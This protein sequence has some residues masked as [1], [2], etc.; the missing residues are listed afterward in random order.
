MLQNRE[1]LLQALPALADSELAPAIGLIFKLASETSSS[2]S[3]AVRTVRQRVKKRDALPGAL[4]AIRFAVNHQPD[5]AQEMLIDIDADC[6]NAKPL[7]DVC[8]L[9]LFTFHSLCF[10][11]LSSI[12]ITCLKAQDWCWPQKSKPKMMVASCKLLNYQKAVSSKS[13]S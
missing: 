2:C 6:K 9:S 11:R 13:H 8:F 3:D 4:E 1:Y 12:I 5:I 7:S 10:S